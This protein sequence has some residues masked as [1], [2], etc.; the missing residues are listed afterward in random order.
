MKIRSWLFILILILVLFSI[1]SWLPILTPWRYI[2]NEGIRFEQTSVALNYDHYSFLTPYSPALSSFG[3]DFLH[4]PP[5]YSWLEYPFIKMT[6]SI[7]A[8]RF[9][10]FLFAVATLVIVYKICEL[11]RYDRKTRFMAVLFLAFSPL[12]LWVSTEVMQ[13]TTMLFFSTLSIFF[14]L[15]Y[16]Q[17][18]NNRYLLTTGFAVFLSAFAK[19]PGIFTLIPILVYLYHKERFKPLRNPSF[20]FMVLLPIVLCGAWMLH[21]ESISKTSALGKTQPGT[22]LALES[23]MQLLEVVFQ[24][25]SRFL[26]TTLLF[27]L[28]GLIYRRKNKEFS[29]LASWLAAGVLF[30]FIFLQAAVTF[31]HHYAALMLPP[32]ALLAAQGGSYLSGKLTFKWKLKKYVFLLII[33]MITIALAAGALTYLLL[34]YTKSPNFQTYASEL[35]ETGQY[36]NQITTENDVIAVYKNQSVYFFLSIEINRFKCFRRPFRESL[37]GLGFPNIV[38]VQKKEYTSG[39]IEVSQQDLDDILTLDNYYIAKDLSYFCI[40]RKGSHL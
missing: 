22:I 20:Y 30:Y 1:L 38:I 24:W 35:E 17:R 23:P 36:V 19:W 37:E 12:F 15:K 11:L 9:I 18:N 13:E 26:P 5:L 14:L 27:A 8:G 32:V 39:E 4:L 25:G 10:S 28:I 40:I 6:G 31:H 3:G 16:F 7:E 2:R 21:I 29:L 34:I 33:A